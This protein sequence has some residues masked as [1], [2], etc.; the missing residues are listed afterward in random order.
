MADSKGAAKQ[1]SG[2]GGGSGKKGKGRG[3]P[4]ES[5]QKLKLWLR[6]YP[7]DISEAECREVCTAAHTRF[8]SSTSHRGGKGERGCGDSFL[9][10]RVARECR[11]AHSQTALN[12]PHFDRAHPCSPL[13]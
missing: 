3:G 8:P 2:S 13:S 7:A 5:R 10:A 6:G 4:R 1:A 11:I 9:D 12:Q